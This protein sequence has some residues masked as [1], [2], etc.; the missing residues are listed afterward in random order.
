VNLSSGSARDNLSQDKIRGLRFAVPPGNVLKKFYDIVNPMMLKVL[1]NLKENLA[2]SELRDWLLPM[3]MNGQVKIKE[4]AEPKVVKQVLSETKPTNSYFYQ[5]QLVAA[6]VNAS[7]KHKIAHG[8]MTLAKYTYLIDKLYGVPTYFNY[9]RLHLGPYPK[10]MK[11]IV[12]NKKFFKIQNNEVSVVPQEKEYNYQ[13]QKQVEEAVEELAS[14]FNQYK[15]QE[16]SHQTEL[17]A[18]VCK[19][20]EDIKSTDLKQVRESMKNWPI[21]LKTSKFK[22]KAEKFG[23][24]ETKECLQII[25]ER[26]IN[27]LIRR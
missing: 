12:N 4:A 9:E 22:N 26:W 2:L 20:V 14:I 11:R 8:E 23:E 6:I 16:R 21:D 5:T 1:A 27:H 7:K 24:K 10:E 19:V 13:F 3:L 18:T 25:Q 17:L 15:G